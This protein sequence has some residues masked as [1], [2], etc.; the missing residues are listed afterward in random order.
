MQSEF[1][2][3]GDQTK[4]SHKPFIFFNDIEDIEYHE[5][6]YCCKE[7][8][9]SV[10]RLP[11]RLANTERNTSNDVEKIGNIKD[12]SLFVRGQVTFQVIDVS[13]DVRLIKRLVLDMLHSTELS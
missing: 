5:D 13:G 9:V 4:E 11:K 1:Q 7:V 8:D 3:H 10:H 2:R 12:T 6:H